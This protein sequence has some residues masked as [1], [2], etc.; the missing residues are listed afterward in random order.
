MEFLLVIYPEARK[1]LLDGK[2]IGDT[3]ET[4]VVNKCTHK[5]SLAGAADYHPLSVVIRISGTT[6]IKPREVRFE[7]NN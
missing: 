1:V 4:L 7:K 6:A 2:E 3:N 5:V